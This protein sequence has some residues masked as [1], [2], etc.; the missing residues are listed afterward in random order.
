MNTLASASPGGQETFICSSGTMLV[1]VWDGLGTFSCCGWVHLPNNPFLPQ[2]RLTG[3]FGPAPSPATILTSMAHVSALPLSHA[4]SGTRTGGGGLFPLSNYL[5][6]PLCTQYKSLPLLP[7]WPMGR[8][9]PIVPG[10]LSTSNGLTLM[11][12]QFYPSP[13]FPYL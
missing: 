9:S 8:D 6:S 1:W 4:Q 12:W 10:R 11:T 5:A 7:S 3:L 13:Q 2:V